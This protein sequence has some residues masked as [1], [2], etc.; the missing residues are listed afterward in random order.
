[1]QVD[2]VARL[3]YGLLK[4]AIMAAMR[5]K[6]LPVEKDGKP[7]PHTATIQYSFTIY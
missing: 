4:Q 7:E 1:L 6:F 5:M 3:E 2:V